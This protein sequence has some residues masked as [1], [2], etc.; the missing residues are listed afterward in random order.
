MNGVDA[1][2]LAT[3][4]FVPSKPGSSGQYS[5]LSHAKIENGVFTFWLE[6]PLALGTVGGPTLHP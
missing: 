3:K 2:V 1:V 6:I 5:S 4:T